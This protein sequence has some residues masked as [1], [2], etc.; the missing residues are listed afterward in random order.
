MLK[1]PTKISEIHLKI[2]IAGSLIS[3]IEWINCLLELADP[4]EFS[5]IILWEMMIRY[6][7]HFGKKSI[8][9]LIAWAGLSYFSKSA[10]ARLTT[11]W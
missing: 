1:R 7:G 10:N 9:K 6:F 4:Q 2:E 11:P 3:F 8:F 5:D